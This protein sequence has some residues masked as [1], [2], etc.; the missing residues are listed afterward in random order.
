MIGKIKGCARAMLALSGLSTEFWPNAVV[1][2]AML[3]RY[4]AQGRD[5][6][7]QPVFGARCFARIKQEITD[8]FAPRAIRATYLG[9][10]EHVHRGKAVLLPSG[11]I[12]INSVV[13]E[14]LDVGVQELPATYIPDEVK[15][16]TTPPT[17]QP[18][19]GTSGTAGEASAHQPAHTSDS[20]VEGDF[21]ED[22]RV[23]SWMCPAC[24]GMHRAHTR[25]R[26]QCRLAGEV[27]EAGPRPTTA[28]RNSQEEVIVEEPLPRTVLQEL[29]HRAAKND[30]DLRNKFF[31]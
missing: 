10:V 22:G 8:D 2:A 5:V 30:N 21:D 7:K 11:Y 17:S 13:Q 3:S 31:E 9:M 4:H 24:R 12:D 18:A 20:K 19:G 28:R 14:V 23:S 6:E 15:P 27:A 29:M 16:P 26:G 1:H 25:V